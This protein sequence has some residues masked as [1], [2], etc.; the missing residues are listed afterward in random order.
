M[1][2]LG[3]AAALCRICFRMTQAGSLPTSPGEVERLSPGGN[4]LRT[5]GWDLSLLAAAPSLLA[6]LPQTTLNKAP[7]P[8]PSHSSIS[9]RRP[10]AA[11][12][13]GRGTCVPA[14]VLSQLMTFS[15]CPRVQIPSSKF[16]SHFS[17]LLLRL[18]RVK[19]CAHTSHA[20]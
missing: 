20:L 3:N 5:I 15:S 9:V 10:R 6:G 11:E 19:T 18:I 14:S 12:K 7:H 13:Q 1:V 16:L 17:S 8:W 2:P 4:T